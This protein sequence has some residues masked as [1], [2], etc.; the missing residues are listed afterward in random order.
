MKKQE[1]TQQLIWLYVALFMD[2]KSPKEIA[3]LRDVSPSTV[4]RY[5]EE[6]AKEYTR[7]TGI[8]CS[9]EDLLRAPE[10]SGTRQSFKGRLSKGIMLKTTEGEIEKTSKEV[11]DFIDE[12]VST[13]ADRRMLI[14]E[15]L[16]SEK[17]KG[18]AT[19]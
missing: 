13:L 11:T 1:R 10:H 2:G 3:T 18:G 15:M 5:L 6:I 7:I 9:R 8:P 4:Y 14:A 19:A 12:T 16:E 17:M